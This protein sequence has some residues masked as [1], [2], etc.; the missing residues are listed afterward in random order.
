MQEVMVSA[1][2]MVVMSVQMALMMMRHFSGMRFTIT[3]CVVFYEV[4]VVRK[5]FVEVF[6]PNR[7]LGCYDDNNFYF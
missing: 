4:F 6:N 3:M 1:P 5:K 7:S 2:T